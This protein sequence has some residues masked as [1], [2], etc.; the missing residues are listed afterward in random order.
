MEDKAHSLS[1]VYRDRLGLSIEMLQP[2][3]YK[4]SYTLIDPE[5]LKKKFFVVIELQGAR[6]TVLE[7]VPSVTELNALSE[8]L[9]RDGEIYKFLKNIRRA[10]C[11]YAQL[12]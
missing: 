12:G 8:E 2:N 9:S 3:V 1:Q 10:F 5:N 4:F 11:K 7:C 6:A